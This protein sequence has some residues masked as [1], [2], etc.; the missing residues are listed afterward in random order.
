MLVL[1]LLKFNCRSD[2]GDRMGGPAEN[3]GAL[4][5]RSDQILEVVSHMLLQCLRAKAFTIR[6]KD[7][8]KTKSPVR[9]SQKSTTANALPQRVENRERIRIPRSFGI[10][11]PHQRNDIAG[12]SK[13]VHKITRPQSQ[14]QPRT[15]T[16]PPP[17]TCPLTHHKRKTPLTP[18]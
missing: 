12:R 8:I 11:T 3:S 7:I 10:S 9:H 13:E 2:S 1:V 6:A 14:D 15:P 4:L 5:I 16:P 18:S 17:P